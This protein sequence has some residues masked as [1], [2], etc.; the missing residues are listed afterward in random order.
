MRAT[1]QPKTTVTEIPHLKEVRK[2]HVVGPQGYAEAAAAVGVGP[3]RLVLRASAGCTSAR[4][5]RGRNPRSTWTFT[6]IDVTGEVDNPFADFSNGFVPSESLIL[7]SG[8]LDPRDP[9]DPRDPG[10]PAR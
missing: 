4:P 2:F 6:T 3:R 5:I 9:R 8:W 10:S 7:R 1:K